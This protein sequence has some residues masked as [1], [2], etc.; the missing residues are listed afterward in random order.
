MIPVVCRQIEVHLFRRRK[1]RV[2]FLLLR[3]SAHR[4]LAGVWQPVT[5][6]IEPREP[7]VQAAAREVFEETGLT[8]VRMWALE[9]IAVFYEPGRDGVFVVPVFAAE[10]AWTDPVHLSEE[11]DRYV[12]ATAARASSLVLWETQRA[13]IAAVRREVLDAPV[14]AAAREVTA[15]VR[16]VRPARGAEPRR[17][18]RSTSRATAA[19]ESRPAAS[20]APARRRAPAASSSRST[21]ARAS[22]SA[23]RPRRR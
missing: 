1:G 10:I 9:H 2:E 7:V 5:G 13:A 17:V 3:R 14:H 4:S 11:H 22:R 19:R 20:A 21:A 16:P 8:P 23:K 12:F 15:R 6:G 18:A